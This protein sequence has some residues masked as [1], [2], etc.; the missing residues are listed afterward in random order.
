MLLL[1]SQRITCHDMC[2]HLLSHICKIFYISYNKDLILIVVKLVPLCSSDFTNF[3]QGVVFI[4]RIYTFQKE[5]KSW[6]E[7][8]DLKTIGTD[9]KSRFSTLVSVVFWGVF[10]CNSIFPCTG[11]LLC[12]MLSYTLVVNQIFRCN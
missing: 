12:D 11:V 2:S 6:L 9:L 5:L 8:H 4:T 1:F 7:S 3:L 10:V